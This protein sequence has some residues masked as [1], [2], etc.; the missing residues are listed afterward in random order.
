MEYNGVESRRSIRSGSEGE[1]E[2]VSLENVEEDNE[3]GIGCISNG[4]RRESWVGK[5]AGV[6]GS[7]KAG[8]G[9]NADRLVDNA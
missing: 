9:H 3:G 7:H 4:R 8:E 6:R 1:G 5:G 2:G